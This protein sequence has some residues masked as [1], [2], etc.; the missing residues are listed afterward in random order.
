MKEPD[1][2]MAKRLHA[3]IAATAPSSGRKPGT[4]CPP[5][6][7]TA[8][9]SASSRERREVQLQI[10]DARLRRSSEP[11]RRCHVADLLRA[12]RADR[13]RREEDRSAREEGGELTTRRRRGRARV[14][15]L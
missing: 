12:A 11:R 5:S 9:S 8:R 1:R 6:P 4:E 15:A 13:R 3:I 7:R 2:A 14:P 10:R